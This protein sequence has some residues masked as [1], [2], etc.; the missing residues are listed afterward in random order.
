MKSG[1]SL[2]W[3]KKATR[4]KKYPAGYKQKCHTLRG[5]VVD[6]IRY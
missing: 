6:K 3:T 1:L 2:V 5:I 4:F